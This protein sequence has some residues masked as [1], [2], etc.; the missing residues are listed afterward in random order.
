MQDWTCNICQRLMVG[1]QPATGAANHAVPG[2]APGLQA[3]LSRQQREAVS[4]VRPLRRA[5]DAAERI[6]GERVTKQL[7]IKVR[8]AQC[9]CE[10]PW[11]SGKLPSLA[12]WH[13]H[14]S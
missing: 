6:T 4:R 12:T 13:V 2:C 11:G 1:G 14:D 7:R 3:S 5:A 8:P 10:Q 9:P